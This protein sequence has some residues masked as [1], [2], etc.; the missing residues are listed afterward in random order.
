M[1][2]KSEYINEISDF[3]WKKVIEYYDNKNDNIQF[4]SDELCVSLKY[5]KIISEYDKLKQDYNDLQELYNSKINDMNCELRDIKTKYSTEQ[6]NN[7]LLNNELIAIKNQLKNT[8]SQLETIKKEHNDFI[9]SLKNEYKEQ[10][11]YMKIKIEEANNE[12]LQL[13]KI[14]NEQLE[15]K[16]NQRIEAYKKQNEELKRENEYYY[17]LYVDKSKGKFYE[18]QLYPRLLEYNTKYMGGQWSI[19]H[20]GSNTS[21]KCD[22][23]F[24]HKDNDIC[25]LMDT[26][27]NIQSQPVNNVDMDKFLRDISIDENKAIGGILLANSRICNKKEFEINEHQGRTLVYIS[28]FNQD[29]VGFVFSILDLIYS[30]FK[31]DQKEIDV[32]KVKHGT[33]ED[34]KFLKERNNSINNEKRKIEAYIVSLENRFIEL[35]GQNVDEWLNSSSKNIK[36]ENSD[37]SNNE[38][39]DFDEI[40]KGRI[41]IGK[42]TKYYLCYDDPNT[43]EKKVQYF[44]NNSRKEQKMKKICSCS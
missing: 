2:I 28:N 29:N 4:N 40:E 3:I 36:V 33:T 37:T 44:Q 6:L 23:V 22:F 24:K 1:D 12:R 26:K 21:E 32:N 19:E 15:G 27:N 38:I 42:R 18:T 9:C 7:K 16:V 5:N 13:L 39:I 14:F 25:I 31:E 34:I 35:Y 20:V 30:K 43:H 17:N 8:T 11:E 10:I 41:V